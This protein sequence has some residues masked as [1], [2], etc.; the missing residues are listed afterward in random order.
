MLEPT[1]MQMDVG[2]CLAL[3]AL[4][5]WGRKEISGVVG[6][7]VFAGA[8]RRPLLSA[9]SAVFHLNQ[10]TGNQVVPTEEAYDEVLAFSGLLPMAFTNVRA[11]LGQEI[12]AT[13]ASPTGAG[14]CIAGKF[15]RAASVAR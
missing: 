13:D 9:L 8:F 2:M 12:H 14:S 1:K 3:A 6:R 11:K 7:L 15:K 5:K 10:K 4:P